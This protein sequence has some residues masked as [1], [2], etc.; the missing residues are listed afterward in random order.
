MIFKK[1]SK[2]IAI[3]LSVI[4]VT[5]ATVFTVAMLLSQKVPDPIYVNNEEDFYKINDRLDGYFI[6]N[7]SFSFS[8]PVKPIGDKDHPFKGKINGLSSIFYNIEFDYNE[9]DLD[10]YTVD[11][12]TYIGLFPFNE[13]SILK[14]N[15]YNVKYSN[16]SSAFD[17]NLNIGV[18]S[19]INKGRISGCRISGLKELEFNSSKNINFGGYTGVNE[20]EISKNDLVGHFNLRSSANTFSIGEFAGE[21][22]SNSI[23]ELCKSGGHI[24]VYNSECGEIQNLN[25]GIG[26]GVL[27]GGKINNNIFENASISIYSKAV[28][29]SYIG[30]IV[31]LTNSGSSVEIKNCYYKG[32]ISSFAINEQHISF[33]I[34][35]NLSSKIS[36]KNLL[37]GGSL[38][39]K[40]SK[41]LEINYSDIPLTSD[42][43]ENCYILNDFAAP[44]AAKIICKKIS[45]DDVT[46]SKMKW[47]DGIWIISNGKISFKE[48]TIDE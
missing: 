32:N 23:L 39:T 34:G 13:G 17:T 3:S 15:F 9:L 37:L 1:I 38:A 5:V 44:S 7:K 47:N 29:N 40:N 36:A 35:K 24:M 14:T 43:I 19:G 12:T 31:G 16:F 11:G 8:S 46:I 2:K 42:N 18:V 22:R 30:G 4:L 21:S 20:G 26:T 28:S 45:I 33:S 48:F 41:S 27:S 6:I 25:I 10:K